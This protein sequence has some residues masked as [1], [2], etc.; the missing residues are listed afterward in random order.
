VQ[1]EGGIL[2]PSNAIFDQMDIVKIIEFYGIK[3][4]REG[5]RYY[6]SIP[7]VGSTGRS[8]HV[9][10]TTN[11][12]FCHKNNVG[13][14]ILDFLE[15]M[16]KGTKRE[17]YLKACEISGIQ[18][19]SLSDQEINKRVE[20]E[21]VLGT[22]TAAADIYHAN[23]AEEHYSFIFNQWGITRDSVDKWS[24]GY[25]LPDRTLKGIDEKSLIKTGL[26][27]T[28][29]TGNMGGEF[30]RGRI[31]FPYI[32]NGNV[33]YMA[34]RETL[35]TPEPE[36]QN[37]NIKYKYLRLGSKD[38]PQIS[39]FV[40]KKSFFGEDKIKNEK[41]CFIVE[42]LADCIVLNQ[43]GFPCI[44]LGST[45]PAGEHIEHLI[46]IVKSKNVYVCLDNEESK[47]GQKGALATG[48]LLF[49]AGIKVKVIDLPRESQK[50]VDAAEY[51]K[52][53]TAED[54]ETLKD[55]ALWFI[56]YALNL[57]PKSIS[58]VENLE[59]AEEFV[60]E[61]LLNVDELYRNGYI[62]D[63]IKRFF[64]FVDRD[65]T[66]LLKIANYA[67]KDKQVEKSNSTDNNSRP[68]KDDVE[69]ELIK[70]LET[71]NG[72][73]LLACEKWITEFKLMLAKIQP[74]TLSKKLV[75]PKEKKYSHS[76]FIVAIK[77]KFLVS[78]YETE[79]VY[80]KILVINSKYH[81]EKRRLTNVLIRL[82]NYPFHI[83]ERA[84]DLLKN[85]D[86][87]IFIINTWGK[88]HIGDEAVGKTLPVCVASTFIVG[89]NAGLSVIITGPSG[90]GKSK[91]VNDY[92]DLLPPSMAIKAGFSDK[93]LY[94]SD[95]ILPGSIS[96]LDDREL[97][98]AAI[99]LCKNSMTNFQVPIEY[100]TV[101][102]GEPRELTAPERSGF[103][104]SSVE[105]FDDEQMNNRC[106]Q[107]EIDASA[108]QDANVSKQQREIEITGTSKN[109]KDDIE[110]C[111]CIYDIL[112]LLTYEIK[113]P[114]SKAID[115]KHEHNRR[116]QPKFFDT[117]RAVCLYKIN[118]REYINGFY[119][120]TPEDYKRACGIYQ[121]TTVQNNT[122]L[123]KNEQAIVNIFIKKN[124]DNG[125]YDK[126]NN[127]DTNK[128]VRLTYEAIAAEIGI[129]TGAVKNIFS[130]KNE[131]S[132]GLVSRPF[133]Y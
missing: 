62:S 53:K 49:D 44:A 102:N 47:A 113:I 112:G 6:G 118:Q 32:V 28:T 46:Q 8:L 71:Q 45:K 97:S 40:V 22:L 114:F 129:T 19:E 107:C 56:P 64:G 103:I 125:F 69:I 123:A 96:F 58:K 16:E 87:R 29:N 121:E 65:L 66:L 63:N 34:G 18:T 133:N 128:A 7:P 82:Q 94:Y 80:K 79:E 100:K 72:K 60:K 70:F 85:G 78:S 108:E 14:G 17:A 127:M 27:N 122:N 31:I 55:K 131:R 59:T 43:F 76:K 10:H 25:A 74:E 13:G 83:R 54:F 109:F 75:D 1:D 126:S 39:E 130:K 48:Q 4:T 61:R 12:W 73:G 20:K 5:D 24:V 115:W 77:E 57:C 105:G 33:Q 116:N 23:L 106:L 99:E 91:A 11:T 110:V 15:Y 9:W 35:E 95:T 88:S 38:H 3:L 21:E 124:Q 42:G 67:V 26:V 52:G 51:M 90:K 111:K 117:M 120:A 68:S 104:F 89:D 37:T 92:F 84:E 30:Y 81:K 98:P 36:K 41:T 2:I 132:H 119:L 101:I 93:Y 86:P 50:K